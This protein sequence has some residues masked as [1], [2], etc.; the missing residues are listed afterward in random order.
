M[1][2]LSA[3]YLRKAYTTV[4]VVV[5]EECHCICMSMQVLIS[6]TVRDWC[7][8]ETEEIYLDHI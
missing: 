6:K 5:I 2:I 8:A 1:P 7:V 3:D 4:S